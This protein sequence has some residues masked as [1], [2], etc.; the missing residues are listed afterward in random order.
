[1]IDITQ[2]YSVTGC[3]N[4]ATHAYFDETT[5]TVSYRCH[6]HQI[7]HQ[8]ITIVE[9]KEIPFEEAALYEVMRS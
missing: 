2:N 6:E 7:N 3:K 9:I 1:M 4:L 8:N 5:E